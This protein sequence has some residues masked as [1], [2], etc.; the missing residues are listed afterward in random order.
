MVIPGGPVF[1]IN[2]EKCLLDRLKLL[3]DTHKISNIILFSHLD[4]G[5]YKNRYKNLN[6]N[7]LLKQQVEDIKK[8]QLQLTKM[9][10]Q[11]IV[12]SFRISINKKKVV[13]KSINPLKG[14]EVNRRVY[15]NFI[16]GK[17]N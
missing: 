6:S 14:A 11:I 3:V 4:C 7:L 9:F 1:I 8:S 2:K 10:P 16:K 17:K 13:F 5:Y 12:K 15:D